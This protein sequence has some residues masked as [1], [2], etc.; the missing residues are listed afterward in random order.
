MTENGYAHA[1]D[2]TRLAYQCRGAGSPLV[3]LAG[4]ANNHHWWDRA[5]ADFSGS[6]ITVDWRGT[7]AS[8]KPDLPYSTRVFADDLIAVLDELGIDQTDVY[9]TSM[10]GRVAQWVAALHPHRVRR[11]VLG[12]TSPGGEHGIER[13]NA[14]RRALAQAGSTAV[15][16]DLM[17][18]P[19]WRAEN[20]GPYNTLG[21]SDMPPHAV[22]GHLVA[23]NKHDAWN[24]LS[25]ISAPTLVL[26]G[27]DDELTPAANV[28]LLA[29]RIPRARVHIFPGARHAY[30]EECRPL[31]SILVTEFLAEARVS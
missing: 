12:C 2:G 15:L 11:L 1:G 19:A 8:D 31:A 4:Q 7:G 25:Q 24:V 10:G 9:G 21:D 3:L 17:Y 5:R 29:D 23:S 22:R 13:T 6:T 20:P 16:E 27:S 30:F 14:V 18:T 26:H 28:P